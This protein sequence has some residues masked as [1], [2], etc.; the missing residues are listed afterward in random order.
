LDL[1]FCITG[2]AVR[3]GATQGVKKKKKKKKKE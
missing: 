1:L 3:W 2:A